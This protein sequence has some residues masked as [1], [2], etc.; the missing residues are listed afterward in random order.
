MLEFRRMEEK[1]S[2]RVL[3]KSISGSSGISLERQQWTR[4]FFGALDDSLRSNRRAIVAALQ[5]LIFNFST[6]LITSIGL[7]D[8]LAQ[9]WSFY[10]SHLLLWRRWKFCEK[11]NNAYIL[12]FELVLL[13]WTFLK[14]AKIFNQ[15]E[16]RFFEN[17][18][19]VT[20]TPNPPR[21]HI[22]FCL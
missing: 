2:F 18:V 20:F 7:K 3:C 6:E 5:L 9:M 22:S 8:F 10:V 15:S 4:E 14:T 12:Y 17:L 19:R 21:K 11:C 1:K 13:K 16:K